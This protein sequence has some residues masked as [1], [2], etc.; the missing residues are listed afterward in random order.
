[1]KVGLIIS[2]LKRV[3]FMRFVQ[4]TFNKEKALE[5]PALTV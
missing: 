2:E 3:H 4:R 5:A 1:M